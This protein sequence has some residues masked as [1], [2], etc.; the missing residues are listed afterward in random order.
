MAGATVGDAAGFIDPLYSPGLDFCSYTSYTVADIL[1]QGLA[2]ENI[3]DRLRNY[4]EQFPATY[5][6]WFESLYKDKYYYMGDAELMSAALLL[7]VSAYYL[8]LVRGVY[9]DPEN[10][11][12]HLP[13]SGRGGNFASA[14]MKFYSR[15][16]VAMAQRRWAAG[17]YGRHNSGW[18]ELYDGFVPDARIRKQIWKGLRRWL[19]CELF[20]LKLMLT[21]RSAAPA[22]HASTAAPEA[23]EV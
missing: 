17:C 6:Y 13:F 19:Q 2:G 10:A 1:A 9:R 18:R 23:V 15:R 21:S 12:L 3:E 22:D 8:G 16:L 4:N 11:F 5:R 14:M 20:N 7:D